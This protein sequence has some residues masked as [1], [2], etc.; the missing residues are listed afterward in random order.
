MNATAPNIP[1]IE[2]SISELSALVCRA[3]KGA[4]FSWGEADDAADACIWLAQ[5]GI[6]NITPLLSVI[7][8][9]STCAPDLNT[10]FWQGHSSICPLRSGIILGDFVNLP[11][12]LAG[13]KLAIKQVQNWHFLLPFISR[14]AVS[15]GRDLNVTT[16]TDALALFA[17]GSIDKTPN[18]QNGGTANIEISIREITVTRPQLAKQNRTIITLKQYEAISALAMQMTVP[19]SNISQAGAGGSGSDND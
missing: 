19:T 10:G 5:R 4:G 15:L 17:D 7:T 9:Q 11:K 18:K 12:G 13:G 2:L 1:T 14:S 8:D 3:T 16:E 6:E